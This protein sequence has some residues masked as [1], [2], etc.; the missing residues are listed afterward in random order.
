[1]GIVFVLV[2]PQDLATE[3]TAWGS[4]WPSEF[5]GLPV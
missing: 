5:R 2:H 4:D 3:L 1:M